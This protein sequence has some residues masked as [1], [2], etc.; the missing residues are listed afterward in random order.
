M[1]LLLSH[2]LENVLAKA[3]PLSVTLLLEALQ[4]TTSF[5]TQMSQKYN[6]SVCPTMFCWR[7][8]WLT[9]LF[10]SLAVCRDRPFRCPVDELLQPLHAHL[11]RF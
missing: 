5:E 7:N 3:S 10:S 11:D 8:A 1:S 4:A 6:I 2:D 9:H